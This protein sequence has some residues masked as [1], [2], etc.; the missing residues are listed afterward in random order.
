MITLVKDFLRAKNLQILRL[1]QSPDGRSDGG[2][3]RSR[4]GVGSAG[5][6]DA[7]VLDITIPDAD[8]LPLHGLLAAEGA[9]ELRV[10]RDFHLL[11]GLAE[12]GAITG[13]VLADNSDL[14]RAFGLEF[15][16]ANLR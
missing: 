7:A 9:Q 5:D 6:G 8:G 1:S 15:H 2:S 14:L 13:A 11:D 10:L 16:K 4:E 3:G 12:G